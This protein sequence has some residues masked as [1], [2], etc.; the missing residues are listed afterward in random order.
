MAS[1]VIEDAIEVGEVHVIAP[2]ALILMKLSANRSQDRADVVH[3]LGAGVDERAVA[4]YLAEHA[5]ELVNRFAELVDEI[6]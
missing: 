6:G 1:D 4:S 3:L 2:E 5:P